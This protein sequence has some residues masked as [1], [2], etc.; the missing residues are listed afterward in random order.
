VTNITNVVQCTSI[1]MLRY[2]REIFKIFPR[3]YKC[4]PERVS[5]WEFACNVD[6]QSQHKSPFLRRMFCN[7]NPYILI[8]ICIY[9]CVCV[10]VYT[11]SIGQTMSSRYYIK[12]KS[13]ELLSNLLLNSNSNSSKTRD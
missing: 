10:C 13:V 5:R 8:Y 12:V 7:I 3:E 11:T 9:I 1:G 2:L 4:T 6:S